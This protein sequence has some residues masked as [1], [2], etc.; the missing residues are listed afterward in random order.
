VRAAKR[1]AEQGCNRA[2][3][4]EAHRR[5]HPSVPVCVELASEGGDL[6]DSV[7]QLP[8]RAAD[9]VVIGLL[10]RPANMS[11]DARDTSRTNNQPRG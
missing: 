11:P 6:D 1:I 4:Q 8:R 9:A 5:M 10:Q 3:F 2:H 7:S